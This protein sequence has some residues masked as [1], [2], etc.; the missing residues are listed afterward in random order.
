MIILTSI[1]LFLPPPRRF[2]MTTSLELFYPKMATLHILH[3]CRLARLNS[4]FN[5]NDRLCLHKFLFGSIPTTLICVA[6]T[7]HSS[8]L[9]KP[10]FR[11]TRYVF[12]H[13][14]RLQLPSGIYSGTRTGCVATYSQKLH[15][16]HRK[17]Q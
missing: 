15:L 5:P 6:I 3:S 13:V 10:S 12:G 16:R 7:M 17:E 14:Q 9:C 11:L 2:L 1:C 8:R 4:T